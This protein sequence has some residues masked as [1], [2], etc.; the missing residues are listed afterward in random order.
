MLR[1]CLR[2]P[3]FIL[4]LVGK[5]PYSASP[6]GLISRLNS[7][8]CAPASTN[9][10]AAYSPAGP[11][12]IMPIRCPRSVCVCVILPLFFVSTYFSHWLHHPHRHD[13]AQRIS[14]NYGTC[15]TEEIMLAISGMPSLR[16]YGEQHFTD[17]TP[18]L[19][20]TVCRRGCGK[21]ERVRND[22]VDLPLH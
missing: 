19:E 21:R 16:V 8:T 9:F 4:C 22:R 17:I 12:P 6:P 2:K 10:L 13:P 5:M 11:A 18:F 20:I 7:T 1:N 3:S 14:L 15:I